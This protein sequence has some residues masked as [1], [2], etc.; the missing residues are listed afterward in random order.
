MRDE[1]KK[2]REGE[3]GSKSTALGS[4]EEAGTA[5]LPDTVYLRIKEAGSLPTNSLGSL[6]EGHFEALD[7]PKH[8]L[9]RLQRKAAVVTLQ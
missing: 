4:Q 7:L 9:S 5:Y 1:S 2:G 6:A 3:K 8:K